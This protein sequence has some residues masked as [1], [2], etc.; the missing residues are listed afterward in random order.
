MDHVHLKETYTRSLETQGSV[1]GGLVVGEALMDGDYEILVDL[2][3]RCCLRIV[4]GDV[5]INGCGAHKDRMSVEAKKNIL[6]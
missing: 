2:E 1:F 4:I 5:A 3:I 6:K